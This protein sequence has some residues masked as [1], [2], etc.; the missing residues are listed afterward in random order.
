MH[1]HT[2]AYVPTV[3]VE[4]ILMQIDPEGKWEKRIVAMLE[5][6]LEINPTKLIKGQGLAKLMVESNL[7]ALDINFIAAL[8]EEEEEEDSHLQVSNMFI[9]SP[10]YSNIFY[11]LQ[12]LNPPP[13]V[14]KGKTR[15]LKLKASKYCILDGVLFWKDLGGML[16]NFLVE[17][18]AKDVM[19]D[20]HK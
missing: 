13:E 7:H 10:W 5:Y 18:E 16:L 11:A 19:R 20:F 17:N 1:S 4:E 2:I 15:S 12:H 14:A 3:D 6:V 8:S 9:S